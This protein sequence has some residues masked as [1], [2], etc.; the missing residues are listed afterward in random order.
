MKRMSRIIVCYVVLGLLVGSCVD[1]NGSKET[2]IDR[3][4]TARMSK[5][6]MRTNAL[7]TLIRDS[8]SIFSNAKVDSIAQ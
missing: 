1:T 2:D 6:G 3:V 5:D 7:D 8:I 4:N